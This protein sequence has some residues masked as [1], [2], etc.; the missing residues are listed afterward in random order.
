MKKNLVLVIAV[1]IV[2]A[3]A[4]VYMSGGGKSG[5]SGSSGGAAAEK[6]LTF[7]CQMYSD[8]MICPWKQTNCGWNAMR[9]G[10]SESLFRFDENS[11]KKIT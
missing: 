9:Y 2:A 11:R 8:G 3:I 10:I 1:L 4:A 6:T 7:G 5:E